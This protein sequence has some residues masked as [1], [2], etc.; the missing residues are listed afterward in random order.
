MILFWSAMGIGQNGRLS[1]AL[2]SVLGCGFAIEKASHE[3]VS[4]L[5]RRLFG[6]IALH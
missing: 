3:L 1:C 5:G 6:R 2:L 4:G